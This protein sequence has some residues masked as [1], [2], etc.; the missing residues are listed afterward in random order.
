MEKFLRGTMFLRFLMITSILFFPLV[1]NAQNIKVLK[2]KGKSAVKAGDT[3]IVFQTPNDQLVGIY[4]LLGESSAVAS[5]PGG[6]ASAYGVDLKHICDAPAELKL[7]NGYYDFHVTNNAML[8]AKFQVDAAGGTQFW[9]VKNANPGE[10]IGGIT[11]FTCGII[12]TVVGF[13]AYAL[14][15]TTYDNNG[16]PTTTNDT[17]MLGIGLAGVASTVG[18][19]LLIDDGTAHAKLLDVKF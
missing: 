4:Q 16:N 1:L 14:G 6:T 11:L 7:D 19:Y 12:A 3:K 17:T 10:A 9:Q 2:Q 15:N 13:L 18:G 5:G 8:G